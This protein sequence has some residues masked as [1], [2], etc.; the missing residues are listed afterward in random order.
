MVS[1]SQSIKP[2][3]VV[4]AAGRV[5]ASVRHRGILVL[6]LGLYAALAFYALDH[7]SLWEDEYLSVRRV[8]SD[9]P[10]WKD[11]HGFLYFALLQAWVGFFGDSSTALRGL[12]AVLGMIAVYLFYHLGAT[13]FSRRIAGLSTIVFANSPFLIWYSQEVR[14]ITLTLVMALLSTL[15]LQRLLQ[16]RSGHAWMVYGASMLLTFFSFLATLPLA[17]AHGLYLCSARSRRE[18]L[19]AW[20]AC[21]LAVSILFG[22]WVLTGTHYGRAIWAWSQ[23]EPVQT[24]VFEAGQIPTGDFNR[25]TPAVLP[26][27]FYTFSVGMTLGPSP[28]ELHVSP[29]LATLAPHAPIL[30][31]LA[32]LYGGLFLV[33]LRE[34]RHRGGIGTLLFLWMS[35]PILSVFVLAWFFNLFYN[36]RYVALA[37]PAY[38]LILALG[39]SADRR[40]WLRA[41]L[42]AAVLTAHGASLMN[43]YFNP[44]YA[45]E[46]ARSAAQYLKTEARPQDAILVVGT[47]SA[48]PYYYQGEPPLTGLYE[49]VHTAQSVATSL[50]V[51][52]KPYDR[53]WLVEIRPWQVDPK[54]MI[55]AELEARHHLVQRQR[56][57]GVAIYAYQGDH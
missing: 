54:R 24:Q 11:G 15:A 32:I 57:P 37:F 18:V 19:S 29:S 13:A 55:R 7:H 27:T 44:R 5:L 8:Q 4:T 3:S 30:G 22:C 46:D 12:S 49:P 9:I 36:V 16:R 53:L 51:L 41:A 23:R 28:H 2:H 45:R 56:F 48:L 40:R 6:S 43:Y 1:G 39:L 10:I 31:L 14:Y 26:Y 50:D 42:L 21:L 17:L 35:V 20:I 34:I 38:G 33:G 25:L 47:L 52:D